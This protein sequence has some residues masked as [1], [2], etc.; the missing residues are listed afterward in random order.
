M[1]LNDDESEADRLVNKIDEAAQFHADQ[2]LKK[3]HADVSMFINVTSNKLLELVEDIEDD[4]L[5]I[6]MTQML[7][8]VLGGL[9]KACLE[10]KSENLMLKHDVLEE[11]QGEQ[12]P[13]LN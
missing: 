7:G 12:D 3:D 13:E 10:L 1:R 5:A 9:G 6:A 2:I 4:S 11:L 8:A